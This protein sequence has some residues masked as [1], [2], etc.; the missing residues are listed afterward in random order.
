MSPCLSLSCPHPSAVTLPDSNG[1]VRWL[2]PFFTNWNDVAVVVRRARPGRPP[3]RRPGN[4]AATPICPSAHEII[5]LHAPDRHPRK[6]AAGTASKNGLL[7][8]EG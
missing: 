2:A 3:T 1:K 4:R 5:Q 6:N 8:W 7:I